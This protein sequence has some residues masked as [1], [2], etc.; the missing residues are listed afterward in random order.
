MTRRLLTLALTAGLVVSALSGSSSAG[1]GGGSVTNPVASRDCFAGMDGTCSTSATADPSR[2]F[3][4]AVEL[5]SPDSPSSRSWRYAQ[6][7]ASYTIGFDLERATPEATINVTLDLEEATA[8][9]EQVVPEVFGGANSADSGA[10]VLF[11]LLGQKAPDDC[12]CGWFIQGSPNVVPVNA[13]AVGDAQSISDEQVQVTMV[14]R[15]PYGDGLLPAGHYEA[16]LRAYAR[17]DLVAAGD[18]GTLTSSVTGS[19]TNVSVTTPAEATNLTL[20]VTGP[21]SNRTLSATLTDSVSAPISGKT[22]SFYGD[23]TFLGTAETRD[24]VAILP[25]SGKFRGGKHVFRA[26]FAGDDMYAPSFAQTGG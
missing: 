24:G 22:I 20:A 2:A 15:N 16:R 1:T 12:G 4:A 17:A 8:A 3:S 9:W 26:E 14:G 10:K 5:T 21:K 19:I 25:L 11:Q 13:A 18:W 6:G 23:G 7:L